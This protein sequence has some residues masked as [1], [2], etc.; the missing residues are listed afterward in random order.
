MNNPTLAAPVATDSEI[1]DIQQ[2]AC[3]IVGGGPVRHAGLAALRSSIVATAPELLDRIELLQDWSQI[4][5]LS[6]ESGRVERWYR[7][8]ALLIGDAAHTMSPVAGVGINYAIQDAVV[9]ANL[10]SQPLKSGAVKVTDLAK[11]QHQRTRSAELYL[12]RFGSRR[13]LCR[14]VL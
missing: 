6:V 7:S 11:V 12:G 14:S 1:L 8:G 4:A 2:T 13:R 10:L 5:F 3:C 9:A